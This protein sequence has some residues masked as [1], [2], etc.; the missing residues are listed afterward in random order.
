MGGGL[1][2]NFLSPSFVVTQNFIALRHVA[3]VR[4]LPKSRPL[5]PR[6]INLVGLQGVVYSATL[7]ALRQTSVRRDYNRVWPLEPV[8]YFGSM[9]IP[10]KN[11]ISRCLVSAPDLV[12]L[13]H[14]VSA[15]V[16]LASWAAS[17]CCLRLNS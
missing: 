10:K 9:M 14:D 3:Y 16:F 8:P 5:W 12:A 13:Y 7:V 6:S 1:R 4:A 11:V 17:F 15:N 2:E